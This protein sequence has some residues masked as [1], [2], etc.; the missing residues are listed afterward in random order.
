[1]TELR[2]TVAETKDAIQYWL[3]HAIVRV[4]MSVKAV[5]FNTNTSDFTIE[6]APVDLPP[7]KDTES[8]P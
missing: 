6:L 3:K 4:P 8:E 1:M 2:L 5:R 7:E